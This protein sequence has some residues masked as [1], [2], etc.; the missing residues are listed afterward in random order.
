MWGSDIIFR[1]NHQKMGKIFSFPST[2][3]TNPTNMLP[4]RSYLRRRAQ[5][6]LVLRRIQAKGQETIEESV[7]LTAIRKARFLQSRSPETAEICVRN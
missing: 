2:N 3:P 5:R 4:P 1:I 6:L 7:G